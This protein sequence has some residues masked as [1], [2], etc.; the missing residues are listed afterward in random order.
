LEVEVEGIRELPTELRLTGGGMGLGGAPLWANFEMVLPKEGTE[1]K[2]VRRVVLLLTLAV[3]PFVGG[4][5][6]RVLVVA[7]FRERSDTV[8]LKVETNPRRRDITKRNNAE[9]CRQEKVSCLQK[10]PLNGST[11]F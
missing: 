9:D 1:E 10:L 3:V 2:E 5:W 8:R 6:G 7:I 11:I 4:R